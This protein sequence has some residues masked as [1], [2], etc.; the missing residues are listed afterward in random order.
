MFSNQ[1]FGLHA[2]VIGIQ[3]RLKENQRGDAAGH[4]RDF[5]GFV[6]R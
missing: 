3:F 1:M 5:A 4:L 2:L 6:R